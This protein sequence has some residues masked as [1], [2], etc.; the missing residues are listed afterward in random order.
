MVLIILSLHCNKCFC[1]IK[2]QHAEHPSWPGC[3]FTIAMNGTAQQAELK[4]FFLID[5]SHGLYF[6][7]V[8]EMSSW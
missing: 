5:I 2:C 4:V 7:M 3:H 6:G 8:P 1:I